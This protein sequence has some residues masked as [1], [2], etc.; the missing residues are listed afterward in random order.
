MSRSSWRASW[1]RFGLQGAPVLVVLLA[2]LLVM[3]VYPM[4]FTEVMHSSVD[5]LLKHVATG[6]LN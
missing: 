5:A 1:Q 6:K 2:V 4:P 3:G